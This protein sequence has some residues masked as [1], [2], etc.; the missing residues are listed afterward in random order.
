MKETYHNFDVKKI[1]TNRL[2]RPQWFI[3]AVLWFLRKDLAGL[4][5]SGLKLERYRPGDYTV[6]RFTDPC[7]IPVI[8]GNCLGIYES[9]ED[10]PGSRGDYSLEEGELVICMTHADE[11]SESEDRLYL[12][13]VSPG[14]GS[15]TLERCPM[16]NMPL[17]FAKMVE[18]DTETGIISNSLTGER[19]EVITVQSVNAIL[20]ELE[21]ELG[22]DIVWI[23]Y[24]AQKRFSLKKLRGVEIR[25]PEA[26]WDRYLV[27][28][29]VRGLG[30]PER[31]EFSG[32]SLSVDILKAYNQYLYAAKLAAGF[33][34]ITGRRS[35]IKWE[36][37][38]RDHGRYSIVTQ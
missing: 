36:L 38:Q 17:Q 10:M 26:F 35:F 28:M 14:E 25:D 1:P 9:V 24:N 23:L 7:M 2:F 3:K 19:L 13:E 12:E 6:I 29:A 34:K 5:A 8:V 20:R 15:L 27:E 16:C 18:W 22:A 31:F 30:Y 37:C 4:G 21:K 33:E 32:D 11:K